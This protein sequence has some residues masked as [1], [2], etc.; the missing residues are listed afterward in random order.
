MNVYTVGNLKR[1]TF[2][3]PCLIS[4]RHL[5]RLCNVDFL[6]SKDDF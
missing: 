1:N 6:Q 4:Q 5:T 3:V 2:G